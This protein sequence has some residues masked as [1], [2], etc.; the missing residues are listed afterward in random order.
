VPS[1]PRLLAGISAVALVAGGLWA[2]LAPAS[3]YEVIATYP[4]YNRHLIHDLGAFQLGLGACLFAGLV[5]SDSLLAVLGGNA[6]G[7]LFHWVAHIEDR[8]LGGRA[9]DPFTIG[10]A[11]LV[12]LVAWLIR[13]KQVAN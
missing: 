10:G 1:T 3:F 4:P 9:S 5:W 2:W 11:F 6:V 7:A 12:L 13:R 8:D